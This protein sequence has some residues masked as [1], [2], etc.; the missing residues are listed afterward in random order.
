MVGECLAL[1]GFAQVAGELPNTLYAL[2][3]DLLSVLCNSRVCHLGKELATLLCHLSS[4]LG[5]C[6]DKR[7]TFER[8]WF[9]GLAANTSK[10]QAAYSTHH[11]VGESCITDVGLSPKT[12]DM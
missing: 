10:Y 7:R 2:T 8:L 12:E 3:A 5:T 1:A 4:R 6:R 9:S 11:F